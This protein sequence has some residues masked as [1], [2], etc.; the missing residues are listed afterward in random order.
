MFGLDWNV[1]TLA[2]R[3][4]KTGFSPLA[5]SGLVAWYDPSDLSSMF[6]D[7]AMTAPVTAAG[8]SVAVIRDKSG[9]DRHLSQSAAAARPTLQTDGASFWLAFDGVDDSYGTGAF[10]WGSDAAQLV[11]GLRKTADDAIGC[12]LET[13]DNSNN[14]AG[15]LAVFAPNATLNA[16]TLEFRSKGSTQA[17]AINFGIP[18][19]TNFVLNAFGRVSSDT[20]VTRIDGI[21]TRN[22]TTNQGNGNFGNFPLYIGR[23]ANANFPFSG[24]L[25]GAVFYN[26]LLD[27]SETGSVE[28]WVAGK[29]GEAL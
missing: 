24:R 23:R 29:I 17:S 1:S 14:Y 22:V 2:V 9:N 7:T 5:L 12:L 3:K 8:Q 11:F 16:G 28:S 19:Q 13:S 10:D 18:S 21:E 6:Q 27:A 4:Q 25:F 26:R 15:T 20:T